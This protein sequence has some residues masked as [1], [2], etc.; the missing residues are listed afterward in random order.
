MGRYSL[1]IISALVLIALDMGSA[2]SQNSRPNQHQKSTNE[3]PNAA[4]QRQPEPAV[5]LSVYNSSQTALL[6]AINALHA[7]Q[8][9]RAKENHPSYEPWYAP[10]VLAQIGLLIIGSFYTYFAWRQ[11][12]AIKE[13]AR[14]TKEALVADKRAF[15]FADNIVSLW[16]PPNETGIYNWR[17]RPRYRNTGGTPT[18]NLRSHV[19]CDIRNTVL[20][21]G[22]AFTA[23]STPCGT[24]MIPP[25]GDSTGGIAPQGSA[26]T[27]QDIVEAQAFRRFIYLWGWIKYHDVFPGTSEHTT[28]FCWM[29][30]IAGDPTTFVPNTPGQPPTPGTLQFTFLQHTEGNY[31]D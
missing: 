27:P 14:L 13:Q 24:G 4:E 18:K 22:H 20:P 5:P 16:D 3:Q 28:H 21:P 25:S 8:E 11:W 19:E 6:Q 7:E 12:T 1:W 23:Q 26:I 15:V 31:A 30:L 17:L 2:A 10:S 29:I 9:A